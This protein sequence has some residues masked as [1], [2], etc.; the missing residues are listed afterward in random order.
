MVGRTKSEKAPKSG[1][2]RTA[3]SGHLCTLMQNVIEL[4]KCTLG[5]ALSLSLSFSLSIYAIIRWWWCYASICVKPLSDW[6]I[7]PFGPGDRNP[8]TV[9]WEI[10]W[11]G[12]VV[13][14]FM[15]LWCTM[16]VIPV[17]HRFWLAKSIIY[18]DSTHSTCTYLSTTLSYIH[19]CTISTNVYYFAF[20]LFWKGWTRRRLIALYMYN[21]KYGG[22]LYFTYIGHVNL[23]QLDDRST[24]FGYLA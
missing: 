15:S 16:H 9:R 14:D 20:L 23:S 12:L 21:N 13:G 6:R 8:M 5:L 11:L 3:I 17:G 4:I 7:R 19:Q 18:S 22:V 24:I 1:R 2:F 10:S